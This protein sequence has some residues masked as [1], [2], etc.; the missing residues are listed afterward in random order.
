MAWAELADC[1]REARVGG[2]FWGPDCPRDDDQSV[3]LCASK[4]SKVQALLEF[5]RAESLLEGARLRC[6]TGVP[7]VDRGNLRLL[8]P[9]TDPWSLAGAASLIIADADDEALLPA[10]LLGTPTHII[11]QGCFAELAQD[12]GLSPV[13][14]R[15]ILALRYR[16]PFTMAP[17][18][19]RQVIEIL[20]R[21][22]RL[23]HANRPVAELHGIAR[24]KRV[25]A[26]AMLWDGTGPVRHA[27]LR[28][29][30][31]SPDRNIALAWF[32]RSD[33]AAIRGCTDRGLLVGEIED[34]MIRSIGL[35][36]NCVPPLSIVVDEQGPHFDPAIATDLETILQTANFAEELCIRAAALRRSL[37][38]AGIGKYSHDSAAAKNRRWADGERVVLVTGQVEDDRSI[39]L[40]AAGLTNLEL[41]RR[42][43]ALE[44]GSRLI[45]KP[46]PDVE[47]GH[48]AGHIADAE[49]LVF[50]NEI[51]RT[52]SMAALLEQVDAMHVL[53]SLAGFEGLLRGVEI[54]THGVPFYA[55]WGLTRDLG[56]VPSRRTR[57]LSLDQLVAGCLILY[58]RYLDPVTRL[59]CEPEIVVDRIVAG[60]ARVR[61]PLVALR[62]LQ[63]QLSRLVKRRKIHG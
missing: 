47:A 12:G 50:A 4:P 22:R 15:E 36:A 53:T 13:L 28:K 10:T 25:T 45:F 33:P 18:P 35:G 57:R 37:V 20:A 19:A 23:M 17:I 55:G 42:A 29:V 8:P 6:A 43:R 34:G 14:E 26:D 16:D 56:P 9:E 1:L 41:L 38:A 59:P 7:P 30:I 32:S 11:G 49:A 58:P 40:G 52:S 60:Q 21:W 63:G 54:V 3:I 39:L 51:D 27:P 5:A 24:W 44:P 46:H 48:R 62:Q 61:S 2:T 31:A